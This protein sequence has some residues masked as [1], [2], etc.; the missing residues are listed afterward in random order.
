[1]KCSSS[2]EN[3][4]EAGQSADLWRH[5]QR[6]GAFLWGHAGQQ[7]LG[8]HGQPLH[9]GGTPRPVQ[10]RPRGVGQVGRCGVGVY[11]Q[12]WAKYYRTV[13]TDTVARVYKI[14]R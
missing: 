9:P 14:S 11:N 4:Q 1:M 7:V 12:V 2:A 6:Y 10:G 3:R 8:H 13:L 5:P